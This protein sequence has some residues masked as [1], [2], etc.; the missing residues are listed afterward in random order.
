VP[1]YPDS[2]LTAPRS[3]TL[4]HPDTPALTRRGRVLRRHA[5]SRRANPAILQGNQQSMNVPQT[6][7]AHLV[8][9]VVEIDSKSRWMPRESLLIKPHWTKRPLQKL[10]TD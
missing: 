2:R 4:V 8:K 3:F 1:F 5:D 9:V 10:V 7:V 6:R